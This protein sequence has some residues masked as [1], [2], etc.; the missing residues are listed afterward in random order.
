MLGCFIQDTDFTCSKILNSFFEGTIVNG[1]CFD[2]VEICTINSKGTFNGASF[3]KTSSLGL[4]CSGDGIIARGANFEAGFSSMDFNT[5]IR[6][7]INKEATIN[8]DSNLK[9]FPEE[10]LKHLENLIDI[11]SP[12][13]FYCHTVYSI[14]KGQW[15]TTGWQFRDLGIF[16][17]NDSKIIFANYD[18]SI[19]KI[20]EDKN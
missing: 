15:K 4:M 14:K 17:K 6:S 10:K 7:I 9:N 1:C 11:E 20:Q 18:D 5:N 8:L 19:S 16:T 13:K 12:I 3:S 2:G